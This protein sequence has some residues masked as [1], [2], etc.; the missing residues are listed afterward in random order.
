MEE[1]QV[2]DRI[3]VRPGQSV[4]VDGGAM[5]ITTGTNTPATLSASL[6]M[7]ALDPDASSTRRIIWARV[8]SSPTRRASKVKEPDLLVGTGK[9]AE[10][11]ILVKSAE[12]L[13]TLH[14]IDTVVL[15]KTGTLTQGRPKVTDILPA[16]GLTENALLGIAACLEAPSEHPLGAAI[17]EEAPTM[18]ATGV[19]RPR[20]QGQEI[21][22]TATPAVSALVTEWAAAGG[23]G[24]PPAAAPP[25]GG[26]L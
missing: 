26:G 10:H 6:A 22:S 21:T 24:A 13:E 17:V 19:A 25:A 20:A 11:G 16:D 1:V 2:G 23:G 7:G 8:V 14:T 9:G 12:A 18:I 3:V 4:P 5:T 15:D